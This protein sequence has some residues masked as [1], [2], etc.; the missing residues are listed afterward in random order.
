MNLKSFY[1]EVNSKRYHRNTDDKEEAELGVIIKNFEIVY[2]SMDNSKE[3]YKEHL[4]DIGNWLAIPFGDSRI[5]PLKQ[6]Y[7]VVGIPQII[8]FD[9]KTGK[10]IRTNVRNEVFMRG[11]EVF[12]EWLKNCT[13]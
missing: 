11:I 8:I 2:I 6:K 9:S 12:P 4:I 13:S 3:Q 10:P 7:E 1:S 5:I